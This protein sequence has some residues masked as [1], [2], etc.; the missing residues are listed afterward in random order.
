MPITAK[1]RSPAQRIQ[2]V[3]TLTTASPRHAKSIVKA[4]IPDNVN[5]PKGLSLDMKSQGPAVVVN[6]TGADALTLL[7]TLDE[8]LE[9]VSISEK[10]VV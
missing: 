5:F 4:L 3:I 9:H 2:I 1:H 8:V 10:V 6:L 7:S